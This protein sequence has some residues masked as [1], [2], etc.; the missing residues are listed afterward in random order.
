M[1]IIERLFIMSAHSLA[2]SRKSNSL[3][4]LSFQTPLNSNDHWA[5][6]SSK[7]NFYLCKYTNH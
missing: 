5:K 7:K 3:F 2:L 6:R 4:N 1:A